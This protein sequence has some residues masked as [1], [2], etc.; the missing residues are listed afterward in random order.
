[1]GADRHEIGPLDAGGDQHVL[2]GAVTEEDAKAETG[3]L[4]HAVG[5]AVD[6][7]HV[8]PAGQ[9]N[10][11]GDLA[12]TGKADHQHIRARAVEILFQ[13]VLFRILRRQPPRNH[14]QKRR[15]RH[16]KRDN[17][18]E[19]RGGCLRKQPGGRRRGEKHETEFAALRQKQ[20]NPARCITRGA[21]DAAEAI[22]QGSLHRHHRRHGDQDED[23]VLINDMDVQ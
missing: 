16:G 10:L 23:D 4:A 13:L 12:E 6:D 20:R 11:R 18:N 8:A 21:R 17:G 5:R 9:K 1:M 19:D 15:Q 2:A 22:D 7:G 3:G 14:G